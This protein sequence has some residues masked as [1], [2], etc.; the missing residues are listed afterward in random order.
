MGALGGGPIHHEEG[1]L[2]GPTLPYPLQVAY[3][4]PIRIKP[5][6]IQSQLPSFAVE[7]QHGISYKLAFVPVSTFALDAE[8]ISEITLWFRRTT[9]CFVMI[10]AA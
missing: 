5:T 3:N 8:R 6:E 10:L 4:P 2:P 9:D 1:C 7:G